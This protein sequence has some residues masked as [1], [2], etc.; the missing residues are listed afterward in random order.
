[1]KFE[2]DV[3]NVDVNMLKVQVPN[4]YQ[5]TSRCGVDGCFWQGINEAAVE[6]HRSQVHVESYQTL[7]SIKMFEYNMP[8]VRSAN[9]DSEELAAVKAHEAA[10]VVELAE[11]NLQQHGP[12]FPH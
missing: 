1:M 3:Q 8:V 9:V 12:T 11:L 4:G 5:N 6:A 7:P 2:H 10:K